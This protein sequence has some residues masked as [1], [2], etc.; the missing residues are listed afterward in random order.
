MLPGHAKIETGKGFVARKVSDQEQLK[1]EA[2]FQAF[3][4]SSET[5]P[6]TKVLDD[7]LMHLQMEKQGI[8]MQLDKIP[9]AP[10]S[11][12][13]RQKRQDLLARLDRVNTQVTQ[14]KGNLRELNK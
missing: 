8:E 2:Q 7:K 9:E 10:K 4:V 11:I 13:Q 5:T 3:G 6:V 12:A 1:I 14:I